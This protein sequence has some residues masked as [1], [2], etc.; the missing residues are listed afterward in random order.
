MIEFDP[1]T[2]LE[3]IG[4]DPTPPPSTLT[5]REQIVAKHISEA[6]ATPIFPRHTWL[7]RRG[8]Y[9]SIFPTRGEAVI[10]F[11]KLHGMRIELKAEG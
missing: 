5:E 9:R 7:D 3:E 11:L 8:E 6:I 2:M 1:D 10:E 4:S